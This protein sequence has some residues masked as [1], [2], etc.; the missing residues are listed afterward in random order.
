MLATRAILPHSN[1]IDNKQLYQKLKL[2]SNLQLTKLISSGN[3]SNEEKIH[4]HFIF[5]Y[6]IDIMKWAGPNSVQLT[7]LRVC[8]FV[9]VW[10]R[11]WVQNK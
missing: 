9:C 6:C 2:L 1:Y 11:Q 7:V 8:V 5:A 4:I 10:K 3:D